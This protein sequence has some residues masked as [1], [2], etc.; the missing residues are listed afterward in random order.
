MAS[1]DSG[2][3]AFERTFLERLLADAPGLYLSGGGALA[4]HLGHRRSL[5]LDLFTTDEATFHA[6]LVSVPVVAASMGARVEILT[7]AVAFRR[8]LLTGPDGAGPARRPRARHRRA[9]GPSAG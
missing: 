5:D 2:L 6:A 7:T 3:T 1:F 4:L 9:R 8:M